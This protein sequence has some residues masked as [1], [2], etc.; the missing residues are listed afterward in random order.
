MS[1]MAGGVGSNR[2]IGHD[3]MSNVVYRKSDI[4]GSSIER[5]QQAIECGVS[6]ARQRLRHLDWF[7]VTEI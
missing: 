1:T 2:L 6:R 4:V 3:V 5:L 7:E